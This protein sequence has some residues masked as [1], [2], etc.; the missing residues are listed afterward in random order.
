MDGGLTA[1]PSSTVETSGGVGSDTIHAP[2]SCREIFD[3]A[4]PSYLALGM[5]YDEFYK[6]DHT[7]VIAYRKAYEQK[8]EQKNQEMWLMGAYVYQAIARIAPLLIPFNE[9]PKADPYLDKPFP[10][11]GGEEAQ[12]NTE[13]KAVVDKGLAY[14]KAQA[15]KVN[16]KFG[17]V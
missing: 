15:L 16:R 5:T 1:I 13:A 7:L 8:Q 11:F 14:M 2:D 17:E 3:K 6:K 12:A 4:F 10:L 9:H